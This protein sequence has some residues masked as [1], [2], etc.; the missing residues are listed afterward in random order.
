[1]LRRLLPGLLFG[2]YSVF[3][4]NYLQSTEVYELEET[5]AKKGKRQGSRARWA[6]PQGPKV[7]LKSNLR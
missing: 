6:S 4:A 3:C 2:S 1:M 5:K 7:Y